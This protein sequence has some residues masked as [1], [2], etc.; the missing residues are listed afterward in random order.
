MKIDKMILNVIMDFVTED[1][2]FFV[3][4]K[5]SEVAKGIKQI[6]S[7]YNETKK[8]FERL[9][10]KA[11]MVVSKFSKPDLV[12]R[13]KEYRDLAIAL[14]SDIVITQKIHKEKI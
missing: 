2:I 1:S 4:L 3:E 6:L 13:S 9:K 11:R 14:K 12:K 10:P 5:G 7:T 8:C